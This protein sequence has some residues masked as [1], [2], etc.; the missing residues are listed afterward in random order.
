MTISKSIRTRAVILDDA[1]RA[2]IMVREKRGKKIVLLPGGGVDEGVDIVASV[3]REIQEETRLQ[4]TNIDYLMELNESRPRWQFNA[5]EQ[6]YYPEEV[7]GIDTDLV[8]FTADVNDYNFHLA[9]PE[10]FAWAAFCSLGY[11][12]DLANIYDGIG[13]GVIKAIERAIQRKR[14]WTLT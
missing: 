7:T 2:L 11:I 10:K 6:I 3:H 12:R 13:Y 9:E 5:F 4:L 1:N 14:D 8:F